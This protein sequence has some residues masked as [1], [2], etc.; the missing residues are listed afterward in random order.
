MISA[1][2]FL[3]LVL[4][5]ALS[6][7][8]AAG[9]S[10]FYA[11]GSNNHL[12][13][14]SDSGVQ[15]DVRD[16]SGLVGATPVNGAAFD[17]VRGQ[18]F[19][20]VPA[21][22]GPGSLWYWNQAT[23]STPVSLGL[24][25]TVRPDNA[26]YWGGAYWYVQQGTHNLHR[27]SLIYDGAGNPT[28]YTQQSATLT[29]APAVSLNY[30]GDIV[31]SSAGVLYASTADGANFYSVNLGITLGVLDAFQAV[32]RLGSVGG[33]DGTPNTYVTRLQMSYDVGESTLYGHSYTTGQWYT[34][35]AVN[36]AL[37]PLGF[38]SL[39]PGT[40][41]ANGF[42]DIGGASATATPSAGVP[43]RGPW[44][45]LLSVTLFSLFL[46]RRRR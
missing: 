29:G 24:L 8:P 25:P 5:S 10:Y 9:A 22:S 1:R 23:N 46:A 16:L 34:V 3:P 13:E 35:S 14:V 26:A 17:S 15:R 33:I 6:S 45:A 21:A 41:P 7:V 36:G 27:L 43:E 37:S 30:F 19:F 40:S 12:Y 42:Q 32:T 20:S 11:V 39:T 28:G 18:F 2:R 44:L 31:I 4:V 38:S